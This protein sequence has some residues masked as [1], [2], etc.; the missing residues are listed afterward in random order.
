MMKRAAAQGLSFRSDVDQFSPKI[1]SP[2]IDSYGSF[3]GGFYR[4]LQRE[5]QRPIG[6]DPIDS[7]TAVESSINE[8]IDSSVL[9]R[10]QS[11]ETYRPQNLAQWAERKKADLARL[12]GSLRADDLSPVPSD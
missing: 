2:V 11:D 5:Y 1:R 10:W 7:S 12:S 6:A 3:L 8:T 4:Y 9:E